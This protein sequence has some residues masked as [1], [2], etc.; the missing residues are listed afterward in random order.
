[1]LSVGMDW[2][3]TSGMSECN[4]EEKD[5]RKPNERLHAIVWRRRGWERGKGK[6]NGTDW[7]NLRAAF[8]VNSRDSLWGTL[9]M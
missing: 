6:G 8:V 5:S 9:I 3:H 1:M 7:I 2:S 4:A